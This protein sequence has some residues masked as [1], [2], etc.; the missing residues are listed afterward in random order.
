MRDMHTF[1]TK[2]ATLV[3][4]LA[5]SEENG[6][7]LITWDQ[8][9]HGR[10]LINNRFMF[11]MTEGP[12][13]KHLWHQAKRKILN[14]VTSSS[15]EISSSS[16]P[17]FIKWTDGFTGWTFFL[18]LTQNVDCG[19]TWAFSVAVLTNTQNLCLECKMGEGGRGGRG[20]GNRQKI[21]SLAHWR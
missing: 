20:R 15:D 1:V 12:D 18:I 3:T 6:H 13:V 7:A 2:L 5:A 16:M 10:S 9:T 8:P 11:W 21:H 17:H 14:T 4:K 19:Y